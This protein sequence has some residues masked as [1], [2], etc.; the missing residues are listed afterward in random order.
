MHEAFHQ[1]LIFKVIVNEEDHYSLWLLD[2][3]DP[4]GWHDT[5][6]VR[7]SATVCLAYI[8]EWYSRERQSEAAPVSSS[9]DQ[10]KPAA[11]ATYA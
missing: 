8:T 4:P 10:A 1:E 7:A 2:R 9:V 3:E 5:G 11:I 6:E